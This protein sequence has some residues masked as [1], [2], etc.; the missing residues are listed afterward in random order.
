MEDFSVKDWLG[1]DND[2]GIS[3]WENKYRH[4]NESFREIKLSDFKF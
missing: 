2:L 1:K 4:N 3:I